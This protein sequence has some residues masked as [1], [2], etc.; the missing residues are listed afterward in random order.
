[1]LK[2]STNYINLIS[3]LIIIYLAFIPLNPQNSTDETIIADDF[4]L[5]NAINHVNKISQAPRYVGSRN[6]FQVKQYLIKQLQLRGLQV[7]IQKTNIVNQHSTFTQVENILA[8]IEGTDQNAKSI[9]LMSHYDSAAYTSLGAG[10]AG[11]GVAVILEGI[12]S[13]MRKNIKPKND[14]IILFTDAEEIGLLGAKAFIKKHRWANNVGVVLNFEARGTAGS[15]FM[16][17]ETNHGNQQMF[18]LFNDAKIEFPVS[19]S[20][21]YSIYKLLPTDTDLSVFRK[22]KDIPGFNF[23]FID[24]HFNYHTELDNTTNLSLDSLA[25]Q[26]HYLMPMLEILTQIDLNILKSDKNDVYFQLPFYKTLNYPYD[27]TLVITGINLLVFM[28]IIFAG[29]RNKSIRINSALSGSLP[30]LKSLLITVLVSFMLLKFLYWLHPHYS[31]ILQGFTYN[32][33]IYIVVFSLLAASISF[34]FYRRLLDSHN[35]SELMVVPILIWILLS[36]AAA[37]YITG[38]HF[39]ILISIAGTLALAVNVLMKKPQPSVT[40]LLFV[41]VILIFTPLFMQLPVALGIAILPF[42]GILLVLILSVFISSLQIPQQFQLSKWVFIIALVGTYIYAETKASFS[43]DRP[44]PNSLYYFQD[45][46]SKLAYWFTHDYKT[47]KWN[48]Q[49][50]TNTLKGKQLAEFKT[51]HWRWA[52]IAAATENREIPVAKVAV[53]ADRTY[54]NRRIYKIEITPQRNV[55]RLNLV[56]N[57]E[58][59]LFKLV[60]NGEVV[61]DG[62]AKLIAPGS[63]LAKIHHSTELSF[64]IDIEIAA[65]EQLDFKLYE[66]SPNLLKSWKF[67]IAPRPK[68]FI[69][70]PFIDSDSIISKQRVKI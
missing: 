19:N 13:Y 48:K 58:I 18:K 70:K 68:E 10:D 2:K 24:N 4:Y 20:L 26:A 31:E 66:I 57:Q 56:N 16:L 43:H 50:F 44:L 34:L 14:I 42:S 51:Q 55:S 6:H 3:L 21:A 61:N 40:L 25:H 41:P 7:S 38:A 59:T 45:E 33:H 39:I 49:Y 63:T 37:V 22:D 54:V 52:K 32:G 30:L 28:L 36:F 9:V 5:E 60:I 53:L 23:A 67:D 69:P 65:D 8:K 64:I 29:I 11:S 46:E 62:A 47:S 35:A 12:R 27:W 1:M 15:S 17:M